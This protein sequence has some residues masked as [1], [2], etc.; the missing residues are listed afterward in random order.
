MI[1]L[2]D[3]PQEAE[4]LLERMRTEPNKKFIIADIRGTWLIGIPKEPTVQA[5]NKW[6]NKFKGNEE[7]IAM[8]WAAH[9]EELPRC[10]EVEHYFVLDHA[11]K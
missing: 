5:L 2:G 11:K 7:L 6:K 4:K 8:V 9:P 10:V 3:D 1:T